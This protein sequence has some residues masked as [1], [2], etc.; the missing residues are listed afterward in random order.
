MFDCILD[1]CPENP[2]KCHLWW[3]L[4]EGDEN[5]NPTGNI[6]EGCILSQEMGWPIVKSILQSANRATEQ[7]SKT[8]YDVDCLLEIAEQTKNNYTNM[9]KIT[10]NTKEIGE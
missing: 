4:P 8:A 9:Q 6:R 10:S 1:K 7:S 3:R 2:K 5:G